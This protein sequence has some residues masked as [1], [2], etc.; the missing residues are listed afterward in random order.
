MSFALARKEVRMETQSITLVLPKTMLQRIE[1]LASQRQISGAHL[2]TQTL[3]QLVARDEAY[4]HARQRH[5]QWLAHSAD[6]GA[7]GQLLKTR[8][9][10]HA[11]P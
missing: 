2:V 10:L 8:D 7:G 3:E 6:L 4:T 11:R 5:L 9:E 1:R